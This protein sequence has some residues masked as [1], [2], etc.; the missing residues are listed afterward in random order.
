MD[1]NN[2]NESLKIAKATGLNVPIDK[3][4]FNEAMTKWGV[5]T[6]SKLL[7]QQIFIPLGDGVDKSIEYAPFQSLAQ[8]FISL[9]YAGIMYGSTVYPQGRILYCLIRI[10]Q[11]RLAVLIYPL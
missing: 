3:S 8:Y 10:W 2:I 7:S 4:A 9:G 1:R 5:F 11:H 6:Y